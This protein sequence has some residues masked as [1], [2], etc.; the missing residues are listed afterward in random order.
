MIFLNS[1]LLNNILLIIYLSLN[2]FCFGQDFEESNCKEPS[3]KIKKVIKKAKKE[4]TLLKKIKLFEKAKKSAPENASLFF[5]YANTFEKEANHLLQ[6]QANPGPGLQLKRKSIPLLLKCHEYCPNYS[7]DVS[8]KLA[9]FFLEKE[10]REE[11]IK[12]MEQFIEH[13][14]EFIHKS[15][16]Y[17]SL[18]KNF[19]VL[20]DKI[21]EEVFLYKN[22]V[23]FEPKIVENVSSINQEY[24]PM[25][26][27]DNKLMFFTRKLDRRSYGDIKGN[28]VEEFTYS[29]RKNKATNFTN[30]KPFD[31]PF[32]Q[33]EFS[34]YGAATMSVDNKEMII[35]ACKKEKVHGSDYLNCD[36]YSTTY[37]R[38]GSED[39]NNYTWTPLI[40]LGPKINTKDGWEGQPCLSAD[41]QTM[42]F[43]S[44]RAESRDNDIYIVQRD[45]TGDWGQAKPFD[46]INTAG[47]DKSPFFHQD[48]ETLYFVSTTSSYRK[49][50]GG[51]DIF[52]I[53]KLEENKWSKPKNIGFPIN[54]IGDE[55][56]LFVS[57]DG[58]KAY[59][60]SKTKG[61]WNIYEFELYEQARPKEVV[62]ISGDLKND[63][64]DELA[65]TNIELTYLESG[66]VS[67]IRVNGNDGKFSAAVKVSDLQDVLLSVNKKGH[68]FD[69]ELI[70]ADELISGEFKQKK[71]L[72]IKKTYKDQVQILENIYFESRSF[73]LTRNSKI[74]LNGFIRFLKENKSLKIQ[75]QGH[76]DDIGESE[77]NQVLSQNRADAVRKHLIDKGIKQNR[78]TAKG[79]GESMPKFS[80]SNAS[81][82]AKNRRTEFLITEE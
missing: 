26:S 45:S 22:K 19:L 82:R 9:L 5:E 35:C 53:R 28:M 4:K 47:K 44:T 30:G 15:S 41:G 3:K 60:S 66:E 76:T 42:F 27:P 25:L 24:F 6:T 69:N 67:K 52:Y 58:K 36:L 37:K 55:I 49:G 65:N 17:K 51:L 40:N 8:L 56:G 2:V 48:G 14:N 12:W 50:I 72:Q 10:K 18:K 32:N 21:Q 29:Y 20:M 46:L 81:N 74:I 57:T 13:E 1:P 78:I 59:Y 80:N 43:T 61:N 79:Y 31:S 71:E 7:S 23:P 54:T 63:S 11:S 34:N 70:K 73:E 62:I 39:G 38:N 16:D 64:G 68:L 75:I 77:R 33:G